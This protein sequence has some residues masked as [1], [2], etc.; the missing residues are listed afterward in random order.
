MPMVA[1]SSRALAAEVLDVSEREALK[2]YFGVPACLMMADD[3][4]AE[5]ESEAEYLDRLGLLSDEERAA[6]VVKCAAE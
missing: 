3:F 4:A 6:I 1:F 5:Y 2:L